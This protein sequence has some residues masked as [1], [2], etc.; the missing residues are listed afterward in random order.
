[1]PEDTDGSEDHGEEMAADLNET[2]VLREPWDVKL[3]LEQ[4]QLT[5]DG[6]LAVRDVAMNERANATNFHPSNAPGTFSYHQGTWALRDRFV[7]KKWIVDRSDGIEAI[8]NEDLKLKIAFCNVDLACD[9]NHIPKP[10]SEKGAC[11]ERAS[12][13]PLFLDLPH[14]APRPVGDGM[15]YYLM[16]DQNGAAELTRPIISGGTFIAAVERI[17]LSSG[18][19][20]DPSIL[21]EDDRGP[22][23]NFDPQVVRK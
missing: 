6:L 9:D 4:L 5:L 23:D 10:R 3:R 20:D 12:G 16:T 7:G 19:N 17:Y 15:L 1:M 8:R 21:A 2:K 18:D 11:A 14:Y 13:A 22:A